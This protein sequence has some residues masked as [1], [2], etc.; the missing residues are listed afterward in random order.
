M[1]FTRSKRKLNKQLKGGVDNMKKFY[2]SQKGFTLIELLIVIVIIGILS[3][4]VLTAINPA[5][6]IQRSRETVWRS[7]AEKE[8]LALAACAAATQDARNC[9]SLAEIGFTIPAGALGIFPITA[10]TAI[11]DTVSI[12]SVYLGCTGACS[13]TPN[14]GL[15]TNFAVTGATCTVL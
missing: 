9:D 6:Q 2:S 3:G 8:C 4:V 14:T 15:F 7:T 10:A 12:S 13:A 1:I 5:K 11:G